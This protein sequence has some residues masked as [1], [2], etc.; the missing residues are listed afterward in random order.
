MYGILFLNQWLLTWRW[1]ESL[2]LYL[3]KSVHINILY[4]ESELLTKVTKLDNNTSSGSNNNNNL[5]V[6]LCNTKELCKRE[7]G[8]VDVAPNRLGLNRGGEKT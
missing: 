6:A 8:F 7:V 2:S 1:I 5:Y 3:I 4:S